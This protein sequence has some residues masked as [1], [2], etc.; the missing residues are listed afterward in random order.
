VFVPSIG[1]HNLTETE[2]KVLQHI[3]GNAVNNNPKTI[4]KKKT[5]NTNQKTKTKTTLA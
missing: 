1:R 4:T 3:M 5:K 2:R